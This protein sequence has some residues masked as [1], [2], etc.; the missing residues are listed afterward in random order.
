MSC[1]DLARRV[2]GILKN[3]ILVKQEA[4]FCEITL[5]FQL[6][7][8]EA[9][10]CF[11]H[12]HDRDTFTITDGGLILFYLDSIDCALQGRILSISNTLQRIYDFS[13]KNEE[14]TIECNSN[15][16]PNAVLRFVSIATLMHSLKFLV[17]P[18][19]PKSFTEDL[20]DYL[21][22]HGVPFTR[23]YQLAIPHSRT[24]HMI[25][26]MAGDTLLQT[27]GSHAKTD[28]SRMTKLKVFPYID[29][30]ASNVNG[31]KKDV[32]LLEKQRLSV[33]DMD[34]IDRFSDN[35]RYWDEKDTWLSRLAS[36]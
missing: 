22:I 24:V 11:V 6:L 34:L 9:I 28:L 35:V 32:I 20:Y 33:D 12:E 29:M 3:N 7:N 19:K 1:E 25:D 17:E 15:V 2:A 4:S 18:P 30:K 31:F 26:A 36:I 10:T 27:I 21:G 16:L 14:I 23:R 5:P 8:E 13:I